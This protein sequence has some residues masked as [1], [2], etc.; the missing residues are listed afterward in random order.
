MIS[1]VYYSIIIFL[2]CF[3]VSLLLV[4]VNL[5][6]APKKNKLMTIKIEKN[7]ISNTKNIDRYL[8]KCQ[9]AEAYFVFVVVIAATAAL[10]VEI[11]IDYTDNI[12]NY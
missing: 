5:G 4:S 12:L 3:S 7:A 11:L 10:I 6:S 1:L 8:I 2:Q 9:I